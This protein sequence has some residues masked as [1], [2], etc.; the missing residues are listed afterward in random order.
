MGV[1]DDGNRP[2]FQ[3][4]VATLGAGGTVAIPDVYL[5]QKSWIGLTRLTYTGSGNDG[6]LKADQPAT[7]AGVDGYGNTLTISSTDTDDR[8]LISWI[9][10]TD[11]SDMIVCLP[12][13]TP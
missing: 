9:V 4:G 11:L 3:S 5:T 1:L 13:A 8:G 7:G 2:A 10:I 12:P 6:E